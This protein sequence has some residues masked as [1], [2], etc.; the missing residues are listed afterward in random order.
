MKK[1]LLLLSFMLILTGC[2]D[3]KDRT[4]NETDSDNLEITNLTQGTVN[5]SGNILGA[6]GDVAL[7]SPIIIESSILVP[8]EKVVTINFSEIIAAQTV[9][10]SSIYIVDIAGNPILATLNVVENQIT[11]IPNEFFLPDSRYTIVVTMDVKDIK[12]RSL[13]GLFNYTFPT[14]PDVLTP[15]ILLSVTP[16]NGTVV[17]PSTEIVMTFN[18]DIGGNVRI[19][20]VDNTTNSSLVGSTVIVANILRFVPNPN[21][22]NHATNY[23]AAL[24][25]NVEDVDGNIY[26]GLRTW[27]FTTESAV[28]ITP[29]QILHHQVL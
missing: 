18:E 3:K 15:P 29:P 27:S 6:T 2:F 26:D 5:S 21:P 25:G 17:S 23:R 11:I 20:V 28:V 24:E 16:A 12:G 19:V 4:N 13:Q 22:L 14:A 8:I 9:N 10:S 1:I 7:G